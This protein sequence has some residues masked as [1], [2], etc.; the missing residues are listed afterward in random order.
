MNKSPTVLILDDDR[1]FLKLLSLRLKRKFP[2]LVV[3]SRAQPVA[4][5]SYDIYILDND[6][7]GR[8]LAA[9]LAEDIKRQQSKSIILVLSGTLS[10]STLKRLINCG[11]EG[12]FD[13]SIPKEIDALVDS[14]ADY[15]RSADLTTVENRR[16]YS[17]ILDTARAITGLIQD[18]NRRLELEES[19]DQRK[20]NEKTAPIHQAE[21]SA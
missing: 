10:K 7:L 4:N 17:N 14:I 8:P 1:F 20:N 18:W 21:G 9:E 3:E 13:K 6:F 5:G 11:C 16:P 2:D 19:R 15:L 12:A